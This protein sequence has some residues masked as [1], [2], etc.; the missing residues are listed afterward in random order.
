MSA[1][2]LYTH[3]KLQ[4]CSSR[5]LLPPRRQS[6]YIRRVHRVYQTGLFTTARGQQNEGPEN[7]LTEKI[8]SPT[9][10]NGSSEIEVGRT[11]SIPLS[12]PAGQAVNGSFQDR[13]RTHQFDTYELVSAL[14][15]AGYTRPQAVALM[16]CLRS[17]LVNGTEFAKSHFL[18][19]GDLE[20]ASTSKLL[21]VNDNRRRIFFGRQCRN[22]APR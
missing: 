8:I 21:G 7:V 9:S 16:K 5:C 15:R 4:L 6:P 10:G 19:R 14:Q 13:A 12:S 2:H 22:C 20:N 3:R 11:D 1:R 17:L 18:S